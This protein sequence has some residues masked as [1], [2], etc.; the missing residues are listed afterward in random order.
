MPGFYTF[1]DSS[2]LS[3]SKVSLVRSRAITHNLNILTIPCDA[4]TAKV[5]SVAIISCGG[6]LIGGHNMDL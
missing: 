2:S 3:P 1:P 4:E 6:H 5:V